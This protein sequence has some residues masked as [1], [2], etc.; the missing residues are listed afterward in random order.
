MK[1]NRPIPIATDNDSMPASA[2]TIGLGPAAAPAGEIVLIA[3]G[4][5]S[6]ADDATDD[7]T[8]DAGGAMS[9]AAGATDAPSIRCR[10]IASATKPL[11]FCCST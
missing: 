2:I 11:A 10:F 6:C 4:Y 9:Y 8:D 7:A 1:A 5:A 3:A